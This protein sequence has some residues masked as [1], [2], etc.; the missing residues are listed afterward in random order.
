M[1]TK[2]KI[3]LLVIAF[4]LH[5]SS[6]GQS[7]NS[8]V[9]MFIFGHSLINHE[10]QIYETPS[11]QTSIPH[12]IHFL[13]QEADKQFKIS[14]QYGF[15]QTHANLPPIS[16]WGFDFV[17]P[18]WESDYEPFAQADFSHIVLTPANFI[19]WQG[20]DINYPNDN[21]SPVDATSSILN[22]CTEQTENLGFYIYENWPDM[23]PFL[24][25]YFPPSTSEWNDYNLYTQNDFAQWFIMI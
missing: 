20:P 16:Q 14:G 24:S 2:N 12:W 10:F 9:T 23:A 6:W 21:I 11:Q 5:Q 22:W 4:A 15:L 8:D 19:Q 17:E 1:N 25:N 3:I 7:Q 18:A 13:A